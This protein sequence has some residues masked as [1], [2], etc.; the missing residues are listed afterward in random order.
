M[1]TISC[2]RPLHFTYLFVGGRSGV[3][4]RCIYVHVCRVCF[5]SMRTSVMYVMYLCAHVYVI[6]P[7]VHVLCM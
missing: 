5:V 4:V 7:C 3:R 6:Y 2:L 1:Y